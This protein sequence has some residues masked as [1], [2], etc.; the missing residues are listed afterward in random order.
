MICSLEHQGTSGMKSG[1]LE[2]MVCIVSTIGINNFCVTSPCIAQQNVNL[3][4]DLYYLS[5][6]VGYSSELTRKHVAQMFFTA[7]L[8]SEAWHPGT[9]H[10]N[11]WTFKKDD[12][13]E[14]FMREVIEQAQ[15][16]LYPHSPSQDCDQKGNLSAMD[17]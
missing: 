2:S 1:P 5:V 8:E 10:L 13:R 3:T 16:S 15:T 12:D 17:R 6:F 14:V 4:R 9:R 7:E 11:N